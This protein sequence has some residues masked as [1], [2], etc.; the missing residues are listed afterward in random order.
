MT[1]PLERFSENTITKMLE[2]GQSPPLLL[3]PDGSSLVLDSVFIVQGIAILVL[4]TFVLIL[5]IK[6]GYQH[7]ESRNQLMVNVIVAGVITGTTIIIQFAVRM[8]GRTSYTSCVLT[9]NS[10]EVI[11][12]V[13]YLSLLFLNIDQALLITKPLRYPQLMTAKCVLA[14]IVFSW[15]APWIQ[16][17]IFFSLSEASDVCV[18]YSNLELITNQS[19]FIYLF[20]V[21][22]S[23]P[24]FAIGVAQIKIMHVAFK[25]IRRIG[26]VQGWSTSRDGK[27]VIKVGITALIIWAGNGLTG[28]PF[29]TLLF[30]LDSTPNVSTAHDITLLI[31]YCS[32][33]WNPIIY[34][35]RIKEVKR[36]CC[37]LCVKRTTNETTVVEIARQSNS[38]SHR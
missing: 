33:L 2:S 5:L 15:V 23:L 4:N 3:S 25:Q 14:A 36:Y 21:Q 20:I 16:V 35:L 38:F 11:T 32:Y 27:R 19:F 9:Y 29:Y 30:F 13:V 1:R 28:L 17:I 34:A 8:S 7:K 31:F 24:V 18:K 37:C 10:Q 6:S 22:Y 26:N 12:Y